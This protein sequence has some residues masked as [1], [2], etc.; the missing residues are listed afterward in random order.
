[1]NAEK[2]RRNAAHCLDLASRTA[3]ET[4]RMRFLRAANAWKTVAKNKE[5]LDAALTANEPPA[6][7]NAE[8]VA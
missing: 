4:L 5:R 1:M 8:E 6:E 2:M 3:D 7:G